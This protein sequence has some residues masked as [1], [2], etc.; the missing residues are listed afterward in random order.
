MSIKTAFHHPAHQD[1]SR[2]QRAAMGETLLLRFLVQHG[3]LPGGL[4]KAANAERLGSGSSLSLPQRV[5]SKHASPTT[6]PATSSTPT[7]P[8]GSS[9]RALEVSS[10]P[11]AGRTATAQIQRMAQSSIP[12]TMLGTRDGSGAYLHPG[13]SSIS[14]ISCFFLSTTPF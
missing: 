2:S 10:N 8:P 4:L 13:F 11:L 3:I 5:A 14:P 1:L 7:S 6:S 12:R 9:Q